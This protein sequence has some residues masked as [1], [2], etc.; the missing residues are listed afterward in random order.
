MTQPFSN[1]AAQVQMTL[2]AIA[3]G[4]DSWGTGLD[5]I[6]KTI[7]TELAR[8][9]LAT[10]GDWS[11]VWGPIQTKGTDNLMYVAQDGVSKAL[12]VVLRGTVMDLSSWWE[13]VPTGMADFDNGQI[14]GARVSDHFQ[15]A[16][17]EL[18]TTPDPD[19]GNATV[20][21]FLAGAIRDLT[22]PVIYV[23]GHSQGGGLTP[24]V[25]A[26]AIHTA[27]TWATTGAPSLIGYA[28]APPTSGNVAFA[29]WIDA[30]ATCYLVMN[31]LD[32]VPFG[33][34][35]MALVPLESIPCP[36]PADLIVPIELAAG[37][38]RLLGHWK[39]PA[40][41][42]GLGPVQLPYTRP[43]SIRDYVTQVEGQHNHNS[44]LY[45]LGAPQIANIGS[46]SPLS[47]V[48]Q[49]G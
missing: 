45:L 21:G 15:T 25:L 49:S 24:M 37:A 20:F 42:I 13:D 7:D 9:D 34:A 10:K 18:L 31:K 22:D 36:V 47:S 1:P 39:Q 5:A 23:T 35:G 29:D 17:G 2:S 32:V 6:R 27:K 41:Q 40:S 8:T 3:Y 16:L 11:R 28:F 14:A 19:C 46:L 12:S 33:Y 26:S 48:R 30:N 43:V 44:Y 4:D 38:V